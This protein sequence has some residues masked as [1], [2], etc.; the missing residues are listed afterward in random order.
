[1]LYYMYF[2]TVSCI[3]CGCKIFCK[4]T[5]EQEED[6]LRE[7]RT[8]SLATKVAKLDNCNGTLRAAATSGS[9]R[10]SSTGRARFDDRTVTT[11]LCDIGQAHR[12]LQLNN[13]RI[14]YHHNRLKASKDACDYRIRIRIHTESRFRV[15]EKVHSNNESGFW[16]RWNLHEIANP[17]A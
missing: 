12:I 16:I 14:K 6:A 17:L 10:R 5:V 3:H 4:R 8:D 7:R 13:L 9:R 1:M 11:A 2:R 15:R